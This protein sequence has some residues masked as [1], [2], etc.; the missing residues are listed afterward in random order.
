MEIRS[1]DHRY[2]ARRRSP[3]WCSRHYSRWARHGDTDRFRPEGQNRFEPHD[4]T[5]GKLVITR[6]DGTEH[7]CLYDLSDHEIV[8]SRKWYWSD[9]YVVCNRSLVGDDIRGLLFLH[10]LLLGLSYRDE[11]LGD[12]KSGDRLDNRRRNLRIAGPEVNSA[13]RAVINELGTSRY[14]GVCWDSA[15]N[16]W[17]AYAKINRGHKTLGRFETELA[18]AQAAMAFRAEHYVEKGYPQRHP[19]TPS[20]A[21][22]YRQTP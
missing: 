8:A 4:A 7:T 2:S 11:C 20:S 17:V 14:R 22:C 15:H 12:H 10:R 21:Q 1:G 19:G 18:A 16:R 13:N 9:G 6:P 3:G 5:A